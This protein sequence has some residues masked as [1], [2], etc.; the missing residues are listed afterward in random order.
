MNI[1]S[2][3]K[4]L[5]KKPVKVADYNRGLTAE[6]YYTNLRTIRDSALHDYQDMTML[7][8]Y[9]PDIRNIRIKALLYYLSALRLLDEKP[10]IVYDVL[11]SDSVISQYAILVRS[12]A[13]NNENP[14]QHVRFE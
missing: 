8:D 12:M 5:F 10:V 6:Q 13:E 1:W 9:H 3:L 14:Y 11:V 7:V 2:W 4:G